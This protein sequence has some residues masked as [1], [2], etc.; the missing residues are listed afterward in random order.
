LAFRYD[1]KV[2]VES[3]IVGREIECAVLGNDYPKASVC[4]EVVLHDEFYSYDTKYINEDGAAVAIPAVMDDDVHQHI[5]DIAL[6]AFQALECQGMARVDVFLTPDQ[7]VVVNEV[8]TLP[9]F[10][11]ISMYPKLWEA[12]GLGYTSLITQLI[13]LALERHAQDSNLQSSVHA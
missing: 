6:R 10:T 1:H 8:N 12:S 7:Q 9:G 5:R 3:A 11:N 2:L 13:E 4:G